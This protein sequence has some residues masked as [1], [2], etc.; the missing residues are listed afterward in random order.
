MQFHLSTLFLV[1]FMVAASLALFGAWGIYITPSLLIAALCLNRTKFL[2]D[3]IIWA[4]LII[5]IGIIC[6][7]FLLTVMPGEREFARRAQCVNN[8]KQIGLALH[9]YLDSYKHFPTANTCNKDGKLLFSWRMEILPM[10]EYGSLYN[11]LNKDETWNSSHNA[12]LINKLCIPEYVCPSDATN[13]MPCYTNYIAIIGPGTTWRDDGLVK[14]SDLPDH[15]SHTVMCIEVANSGV[16][17]AEPR[18]LTVEEALEG[19]RT[20]KGLRISTAHPNCINILFADS[21]VRTLPSKMPISV[22]RKLLAG[23]ITDVDNIESMIDPSAPDMV[24]VSVNVPP[25][26]PN[27]WLII[28]SIIVWLLSVALLFRRAIISRRK[29]DAA[30]QNPQI[31]QMDADKI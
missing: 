30:I 22:W 25:Y 8:L 16:H 6:P 13:T 26:E 12:K 14:F 1:F 18:D 2:R 4:V 27:Q 7:G 17:W 29:P 24:D 10:I 19:L 21:S 28:L 20:G 5:F 11:S 15:G 3:G 23:E 31:S 9:N